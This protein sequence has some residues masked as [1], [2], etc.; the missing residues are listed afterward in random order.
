MFKTQLPLSDFI[1]TAGMKYLNKHAIWEGVKE[2]IWLTIFTW[3]VTEA[4]RLVIPHPSMSVK[5]R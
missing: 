5:N 4:G 1:S 3:K 2:H